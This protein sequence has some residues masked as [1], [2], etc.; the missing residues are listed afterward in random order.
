MQILSLFRSTLAYTFSKKLS[1][2]ICSKD[3]FQK[4]TK[5][6]SKGICSKGLCTLFTSKGCVLP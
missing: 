3:N 2:G 5:V 6:C 1:D 4:G